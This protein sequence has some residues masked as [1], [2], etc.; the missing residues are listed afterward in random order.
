MIN[1]QC[2]EQSGTHR[3]YLVLALRFLLNQS[4]PLSNNSP[5]FSAEK[6][7][8]GQGGTYGEKKSLRFENSF[9]CI[10]QMHPILLNLPGFVQ[11]LHTIFMVVISGQM[12]HCARP[13]FTAALCSYKYLL[14]FSGQF[15][16]AYA[17]AFI[18]LQLYKQVVF[19]L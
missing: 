7:V 16:D 17:L 9:I 5:G 15:M 8:P 19:C 1:H 3:W 10:V 11:P 12:G 4:A 6:S 18:S 14:L 13:P 2:A